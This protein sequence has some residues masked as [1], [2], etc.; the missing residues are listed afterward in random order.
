VA[1]VA[2]ALVNQYIPMA[3][4]FKIVFN[5]IVVVALILWLLSAFGLINSIT[6]GTRGCDVQTVHRR[7]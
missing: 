5:V 3:R 7:R 1:G 6:F 4:P 2:V